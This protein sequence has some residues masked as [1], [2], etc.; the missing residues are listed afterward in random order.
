MSNQSFPGR[1]Y[2]FL[3]L[4][5]L[6][7][8]LFSCSKKQTKTPKSQKD[9][10]IR[11][12]TLQPQE[13]SKNFTGFGPVCTNL[14][15][16]N[17]LSMYDSTLKS[18][19]FYLT[20]FNQAGGGQF[21][22]KGAKPVTGQL[23]ELDYHH[24]KAWSWPIPAGI[25]SWVIMKGQDGN[26][27]LGSYYKGEMMCFNPNTKKWIKL[28]Q[29]PESFRKK[30]FLICDMVQAPDGDF[31]YGT[32]PK[33]HLVCYNPHTKT[34][35][36]LGKVADENYARWLAVTDQ[37]IVLCGVGPK[38]G[39][40]IAYNPKKHRFWTITPKQ[41]QTPGVFSKVFATDRYVIEVQQLPAGRVLVYNPETFKLIHVYDIAK[42]YN[43]R[44][45]FT[46]ID[47]NH[48][49]YQDNNLK[50]MSLNLTNGARSLVFANPGTAA[51]N[52]WFFDSSGNIMGLLAQSYVYLNLKTKTATRR[53]V[54]ADGLGQQVLWLN[55]G[56]D[57]TIYGGPALG[58]TFFSFKP[59]AN[60]LTSYGQV[61]DRTGEVYYGI[62]HQQKFYMISYPGAI[63]SVYDPSRRWS[64]AGGSASNPRTILYIA[65]EQHRPIGGIHTGP[66]GKMYIGTQPN[67]GLLGGALSVF[68]PVT[69]KIDIYR[70]L[71]PNEEIN[72]VG[73]DDKY[74][75]CGSD[76]AG[77]IGSKPTETQSH[78][79][80][81]DPK[82]KK[83][84]FDH[85]FATPDDLSAIAAV[86]GHAY[87]VIDNKLM[88]YDSTER[89]LKTMIRFDQNRTVPG[90]SLKATQSGI[91]W[92]I[93]GDELARI[94]P[95]KQKVRFFPKTKGRATSGLAIASDGTIYFGSDSGIWCYQPKNP[96]PPV[97]FGQ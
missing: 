60:L 13:I 51:N 36:D 90:E 68:D 76:P 46:L 54:P 83:I 61:V 93:L 81:W 53:R 17:A 6:V 24:N 67:Y 22:V 10:F 48:V 3:V 77:G 1:H 63:L 86:K 2:S 14:W 26:I 88:D 18:N 75:Y 70:N 16:V 43:G 34:V 5:L 38:H 7:S 49:L 55:S 94:D 9:P 44:V 4:L 37:G 42:K 62:P 8:I 19:V 80:V 95:T 20:S 82:L 69:E 57:G 78:F 45:T 85:K 96:S 35:T 32:Y 15:T 31:Y 39:R 87:F 29:A 52:R 58:Q 92:G 73:T 71:I 33:A 97:S 66:D 11:T 21:S 79:F 89:T 27:Y 65:K 40:V 50:L 56:P 84:I 30:N 28:P 41:Y 12:K 23:I 64:Y 72:A 25:G 74:V 91:L 47:D 59:K